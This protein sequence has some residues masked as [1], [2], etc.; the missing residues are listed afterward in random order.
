MTAKQISISCVT[1][2]SFCLVSKPLLGYF[3]EYDLNKRLQFILE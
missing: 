1:S 2:Q 3:L